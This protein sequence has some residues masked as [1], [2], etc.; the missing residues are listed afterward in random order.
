MFKPSFV[1]TLISLVSCSTL[2]ATPQLV[3]ANRRPNVVRSHVR[4]IRKVTSKRERHESRPHHAVTSKT[5]LRVVRRKSSMKIKRV[6]V[7]RKPV[8]TVRKAEIKPVV[9]KASVKVTS[10]TSSTPTVQPVKTSPIATPTRLATKPRTFEAIKTAPAKPVSAPQAVKPI[11]QIKPTPLA[12]TTVPN[13]IIISHSKATIR[14]ATTVPRPTG[15]AS[16][17]ATTTSRSKAATVS[18]TPLARPSVLQATVKVVAKP[19]ATVKPIVTPAK[20]KTATV[21]LKVAGRPTTKPSIMKLTPAQA[22][23]KINALIG[24]NH[25]MGSLLITNDG[26]AGI[27]TLT[28]G[29]ANV[30]EHVANTANEAYPLASLEKALTGAVIQHLINQ[31]KLSMNSALC[32][33]YP[34]IPHAKDISIREL[35]DHTSGIQM[36]E[37]VPASALTTEAAQVAFTISH[38]RSTNHHVWSYSNANFTL[39]A[40]IVAKV[41]GQ[42]F[43]TNLRKDILAPLGLQHTFVYNQVPTS[44]VRPQ[45]YNYDQGKSVAAHV[46][47]NLLSSELGCGNVYA[48]VGDFYNFMHGLLSGKLDSKVGLIQLTQNFKPTYSGGVYYRNDGTVRIGGSDN[49]YH[50][51]YV[52][53][54]DG[55]TAVVLFTNQS[56]WSVGNT[57]DG[58]IEQIINQ[59][60]SL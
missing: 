39:L 22:L 16:H 31:G 14:V 21:N 40:G 35:L 20:P 50:S 9:T 44:A 53:T 11:S 13:P 7:S 2:L 28:Y 51:Y 59:S 37:P 46:S 45:S 18:T 23:A 30:A 12:K 52:G 15:I 43:M 57:V 10:R 54:I 3:S 58:Q 1:T 8:V 29:D 24:Q 55:K 25:F 33:F 6:T 32:Q 47:T 36:G 60:N 27:K 17:P 4:T 19:N 42:S 5:R 26:P 48:S 49:A 41:T 56:N 38:L 34:Q